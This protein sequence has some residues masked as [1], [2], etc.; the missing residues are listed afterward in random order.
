[1]V[2]HRF[3]KAAVVGSNPILGYYSFLVRISFWV[4]ISLELFERLN[5]Y[6]YVYKP[7]NLI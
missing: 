7:N 6:R 3:R 1:M 2:E 4:A 5:A